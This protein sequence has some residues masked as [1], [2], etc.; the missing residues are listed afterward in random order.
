[1][2]QQEMMHRH[3]QIVNEGL[4]AMVSSSWIGA[5]SIGDGRCHLFIKVHKVE[6][7]IM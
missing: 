2:C 7:H 5:Q 3:T 4:L 6:V 1:M